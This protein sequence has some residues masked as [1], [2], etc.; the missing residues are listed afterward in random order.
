MLHFLFVLHSQLGVA[1]HSVDE[2]YATRVPFYSQLQQILER[3]TG[4]TNA[5]QE[6]ATRIARAMAM[7]VLLARSAENGLANADLMARLP[8]SFQIAHHLS[9]SPPRALIE[10]RLAEAPIARA[11]LLAAYDLGMAVAD[12]AMDIFRSGG[13]DGPAFRPSAYDYLHSLIRYGPKMYA[14]DRKS[15]V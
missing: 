15:V 6:A 13:M 14:E 12:L 4:L 1:Q 2:R 10:L 9:R 8:A 5:L 7:T 11:R 3:G